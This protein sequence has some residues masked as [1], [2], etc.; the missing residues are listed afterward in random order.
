MT[1][2]IAIVADIHHGAP[3]HTKRG[4][5]ALDLMAD[6]AAWAN[7]EAP[8]LVL[9]LGDR[10]SDIDEETDLQLEAEV[11]ARNM[12]HDN[13]GPDGTRLGQ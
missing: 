5:A 12:P 13:T 7:S 8:H 11:V 10:I 2:R 1:L 3:S 6:F 4:D 9:D